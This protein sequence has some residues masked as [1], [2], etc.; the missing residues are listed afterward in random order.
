MRGNKLS[1]KKIN[2]NAYSNFENYKKFGVVTNYQLKIL[3]E[4]AYMDFKNYKKFGVV[5]GINENFG[6]ESFEP[7]G[8]KTVSKFLFLSPFLIWATF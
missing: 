5:A 3:V 1:I 4:N 6:P 2:E 7:P 8:C